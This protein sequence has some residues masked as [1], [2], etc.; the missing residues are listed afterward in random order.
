MAYL[1]ISIEVLSEEGFFTLNAIGVNPQL[2]IN[3][4]RWK[5]IFDLIVKCRSIIG[6]S[7]G[8]P[9]NQHITINNLTV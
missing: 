4:T 1:A 8:M 7:I 9:S 3:R 2:F 5:N 6:V